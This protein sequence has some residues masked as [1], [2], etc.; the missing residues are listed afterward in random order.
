MNSPQVALVQYR[1]SYAEEAV[2]ASL[3]RLSFGTNFALRPVT[4]PELQ[5]PENQNWLT[6]TQY[7]FPIL[8]WPAAATPLCFPD[9]ASM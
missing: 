8:G 5:Y 1:L 6:G 2:S 7:R 9:G 4:F 3:A